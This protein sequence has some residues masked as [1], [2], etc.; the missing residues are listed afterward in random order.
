ML[1]PW[2][3]AEHP[4]ESHGQS[5]DS[6]F[7]LQMHH[8]LHEGVVV[9][10]EGR[11]GFLHHCPETHQSYELSCSGPEIPAGNQ[12]LDI[13]RLGSRRRPRNLR[14]IV[15]EDSDPYSPHHTWEKPFEQSD[16]FRKIPGVPGRVRALTWNNIWR[17]SKCCGK[18]TH[19]QM[20][21]VRVLCLLPLKVW[22]LYFR[23]WTFS[24]PWTSKSCW[25]STQKLFNPNPSPF[26]TRS[27]RRASGEEILLTKRIYNLRWNSC[28]ASPLGQS[29]RI[30]C[31][32]PDLAWTPC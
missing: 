11:H 31:G 5:Q 19:V 32:V 8:Q 13:L 17:H 4:P 27:L 1:S 29:I 21:C 18:Y 9:S 28:L 7:T 12:F 10:A 2:P 14:L 15:L 20:K 22:H 23:S 6:I 26:P 16:E 3:T 24:S 30:T 25:F